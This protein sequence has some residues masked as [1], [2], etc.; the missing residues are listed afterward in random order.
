MLGSSQEDNPVQHEQA[1]D[2]STAWHLHAQS[3][4]EAYG[5]LPEAAY[6][7]AM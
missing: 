5:S 2:S 6:S 3:P 1:I 4:C 7:G